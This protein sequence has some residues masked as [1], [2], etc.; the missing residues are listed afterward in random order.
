MLFLFQSAFIL[1]S[2]F[3]I[4]NIARRK[5]EGFLGVAGMVVWILFWIVAD[6]AVAW[7][8]TTSRV[9]EAFGIGRGADFVIYSSIALI[10]YI[11][12]RLHIKIEA[13]ERDITKVVREKALKHTNCEKYENTKFRSS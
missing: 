4:L 10:F 11:L 5:K 12:F 7:P 3:A 1:F 8:D 6:I 2:L 9:A 13:I